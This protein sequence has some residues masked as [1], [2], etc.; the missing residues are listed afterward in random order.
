MPS[1]P[2]YMNQFA[3]SNKRKNIHLLIK[4]MFT[5]IHKFK[6][7]SFFFLSLQHLHQ[8]LWHVLEGLMELPQCCALLRAFTLLIW[9]SP[10]L[11]MENISVTWTLHLHQHMTKI[12][13]L[14]MPAGTTAKTETGLTTSHRIFTR[15]EPSQCTTAGLI[16]QAWANPF[17]LTF[18]LLSALKEKRHLQVGIIYLKLTVDLFVYYCSVV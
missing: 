9:S 15:L 3:F 6:L 17:W 13:P 10:G 11:Q 16:T 2:I 5:R 1:L 12:W 7:N 8:F 14:F 4:F 18:P